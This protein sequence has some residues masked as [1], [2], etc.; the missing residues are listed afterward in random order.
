[1]HNAGIPHA[2][3]RQGFTD[4]GIDTLYATNL[5]G[6]FLLTY[7]LEPYLDGDARVVFTSSTGQLSGKLKDDFSLGPVRGVCEPGFHTASS[8]VPGLGWEYWSRRDSARYEMT[9]AIQ[10]VM[11]KMLQRLWDRAALERR[12]KRR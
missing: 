10:C 3:A 1:M 6:S 5:L 11:A 4:D 9:K 2:P 8:R 12:K 7:L